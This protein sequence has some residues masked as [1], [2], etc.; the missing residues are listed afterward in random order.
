VT[1][2]QVS[3]IVL[4]TWLFW[5]AVS[6]WNFGLLGGLLL[7]PVLPLSPAVLDYY[8]RFLDFLFLPIGLAAAVA[9][10]FI[11]RRGRGRSTIVTTA[12]ANAIFL[13]TLLL[14]AEGWRYV[15]MHRALAAAEPDCWYARSFVSSIALGGKEFNTSSHALYRK[16]NRVFVWSYRD[17]GFFEV[18]ETTYRNLG[19]VDDCQLR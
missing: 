18:P 14:A 5:L 6:S 7:L 10:V 19:N 9:V 12:L 8:G 3:K 16:A 17:I 4:A 11:A 15:V 13:A 1:F 2:G